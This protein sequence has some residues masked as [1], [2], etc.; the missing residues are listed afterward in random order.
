[1]KNIA[2][3]G[4][5]VLLA[6]CTTGPAPNFING[7]YYLAGDKSC[8]R[9]NVVSN[10]VIDC[11]DS[12]GQSTG[13]R[14]AMNAEQMQMYAAQQAYQSQ[15]INALTQQVQQTGETFRQAGQAIQQTQPYTPPAVTNPSQPSTTVKCIQAG[16]YVNCRQ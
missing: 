4:G 10:G 15:Q 9:Y 16:I 13:Y 12:K 11:L 7:S 3:L 6:G 8:K 14:Q 1:M 2:C 5:L